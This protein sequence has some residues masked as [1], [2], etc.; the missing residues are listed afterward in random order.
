MG[1]DQGLEPRHDDIAPPLALID[2]KTQHVE[3]TPL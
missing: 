1:A 3:P 2:L